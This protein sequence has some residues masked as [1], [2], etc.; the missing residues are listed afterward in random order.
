MLRERFNACFE[1][2]NLPDTSEEE[3]RHL[4]NFVVVGGGPTGTEL[5]AEIDDLV[6]LFCCSLLQL[7]SCLVLSLIIP[8]GPASND[9]SM[10]KR[11]RSSRRNLSFS[12]H[13]LMPVKKGGS[14]IADLLKKREPYE[15]AA[16]ILQ[17]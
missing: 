1:L 15:E 3:R 4:L 16:S 13:G 9:N 14:S 7:L 17:C 6:G 11:W 5:A 8:H 2:A 10:G 12:I